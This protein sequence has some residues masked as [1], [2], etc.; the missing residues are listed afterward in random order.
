MKKQ[1]DISVS[2]F[3]YDQLQKKLNQANWDKVEL[4]GTVSTLQNRI[5]LLQREISERNKKIE[6]LEEQTR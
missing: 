5:L 4:E 6:E 3:M 2:K 1:N